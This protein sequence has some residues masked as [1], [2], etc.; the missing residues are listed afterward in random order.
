[1]IRGP[2]ELL[3]SALLHASWN[4]LLKRERRPQGAVLAVLGSALLFASAAAVLL[5]GRGFPTRAGLA[6]TA[7]AGVF[8]GAYFLTLAAALGRA[9]YGAVYAVARGGAM[10]LVWPAA[11]L[12]FH[13]PVGTGAA[14]GAVLVLVGVAAVAATGQARASRSGMGFALACA[15]AIAGYH[16]CYD[17]ALHEGAGPAPVFAVA[18]A[19]AL[20]VAWAAARRAGEVPAPASRADV[21]RRVMAGL[22][23]T[24]SFLLFLDGLSRSG[25][26]V[27]LTL[28]NTSVVFAQLLALLLG[29]RVPRR[30]W[31]GAVLVALGAAVLTRPG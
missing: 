7:G 29:E 30:Q 16:L 13:E 18:L 9:S 14:A 6:W 22:L 19:V 21:L 5:P 31:V 3:A 28:R 23:A 17:R 27:A 10:L 24:A 20:P 26:G 1:V 25:A 8:E 11:A 15:G 2:L 4:A 12:W